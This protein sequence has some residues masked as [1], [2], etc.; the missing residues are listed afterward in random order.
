[1]ND[2]SFRFLSNLKKG[3]IKFSNCHGPR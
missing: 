2:Q 3:T 1:L